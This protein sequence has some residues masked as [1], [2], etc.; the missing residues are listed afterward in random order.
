MTGEVLGQ[1]PMSQRRDTLRI[2]ERDS[3]TEGLLLRPLSA[4]NLKP[5][6][7]GNPGNRRPGKT[8]R[9]EREGA[10][11]ADQTGG[12]IRHPELPGPCRRLRPHRPDFIQEDPESFCPSSGCERE[13][14]PP[15]QG[16][17]TVSSGGTGMVGPG[18]KRSGKQQTGRSR[19]GGGFFPENG[20]NPRS[21]GAS[22][23]KRKTW[24]GSG[25]PRPSWSATAKRK[26]KRRPGWSTGQGRRTS[27]IV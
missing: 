23:G 25:R 6:A 24:T 18:E 7:A 9:A 22:A 13:R 14:S 3:G 5:D 20:G 8:S 4:R 12:R 16:G 19:A 10:E 15:S 17:K 27:R 11:A 21:L 2:V 1:R 26:T